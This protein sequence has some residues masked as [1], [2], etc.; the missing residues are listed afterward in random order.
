[1]FHELEKII[2]L[3]ELEPKLFSE[4]ERLL[5]LSEILEI[6]IQNSYELELEEV[7]ELEEKLS[8][9]QERLDQISLYLEELDTEELFFIDDIESEFATANDRD[10]NDMEREIFSALWNWKNK[11]FI[12]VKNKEELLQRLRGIFSEYDF[13]ESKVDDDSI[14]E[15]S[16]EIYQDLLEKRTKRKSVQK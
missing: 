3:K 7:D 14:L 10:V 1:M 8:K 5:K 12:H 16:E 13:D 9:V 2:P 11:N 4:I 6:E 15:I